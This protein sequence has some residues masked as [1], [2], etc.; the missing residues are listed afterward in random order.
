MTQKKDYIHECGTDACDGGLQCLADNGHTEFCL[1]CYC[2]I[3]IRGKCH[4][5][6]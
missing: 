5:I 3:C 4:N 2:R 6:G 1:R